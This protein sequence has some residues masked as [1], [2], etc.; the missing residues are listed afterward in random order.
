MKEHEY[1]GFAIRRPEEEGAIV[2]VFNTL[3]E[4][5]KMYGGYRM[6]GE[7]EKH[8]KFDDASILILSFCDGTTP[9]PIDEFDARVKNGETSNDKEY[10]IFIVAD[11]IGKVEFKKQ[12]IRD[13]LDT[14]DPY[15]SRVMLY[16]CAACLQG[17]EEEEALAPKQKTAKKKPKKK[18]DTKQKT[19]KHKRGL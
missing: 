3:D 12:E 5:V 1:V 10:N 14:G 7:T 9:I 8:T 6:L 19:L 16:Q 18:A 11:M 15:S 2:Y 13:G 17:L 4:G